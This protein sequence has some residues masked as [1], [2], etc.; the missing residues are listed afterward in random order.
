MPVFSD[1]KKNKSVFLFYLIISFIIFGYSLQFG[2][3]LDDQ[4]QIV[5]NVSIHSLDQLTHIFQGS[6]MFANGA[7]QMAGIYY[8]PI[9]T[10]FYTFLWSLSAHSPFQYHLFQLILHSLNAFLVFFIFRKFLT[11]SSKLPFLLGLTFLVHP[12]NVETVV[13]IADL[14]DCLYTFFGL[15]GLLTFVNLPKDKQNNFLILLLLFLLSILSKE[16]GILYLV[17]TCIFAI[18]FERKRIQLSFKLLGLVLSLY[19][20]LRIFVGGLVSLVDH[21]TRIQRAPLLIR[22]LSLPKIISHYFLTFFYPKHLLL[23]QDWIVETPNLIDFW[24][25][26]AIVF[27]IISVIAITYKMQK[28]KQFQF[29]S[30]WLL[31]GLLLHSQIVP[32]DGTV[33]DRWFYFPMIGLLGMLGIILQTIGNTWKRPLQKNIYFYGVFGIL[34]IALSIRSIQRTLNWE[35]PFILYS[36]D[37]EMMPDSFYLND[38]LGLEYYKRAQFQEAKT[39]FQRSVEAFPDGSSGWNDLGAAYTVLGNLDEAETCYWNAVQKGGYDRAYENYA[40]LLYLRGKK[41]DAR[42][43][44]ETR[45]LKLFPNNPLLRSIYQRLI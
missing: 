9:M 45:A 22:L 8:K 15:L 36:H 11:N 5:E 20:S 21:S 24:I 38:D 14:Q 32:L 12:I 2:F 37:L 1:I 44:L 28:T 35:T 3:V 39:Y 19:L 23:T 7:T 25:P 33:A 29:F 10:A 42:Q 13:Y 6:T 4:K 41:T 43:F 40:K 30:L 27:F 16:T 31:F 18:L 26:C 17:M 34:L